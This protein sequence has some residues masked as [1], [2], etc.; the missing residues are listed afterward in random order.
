[1]KQISEIQD[2]CQTRGCYKPFSDLSNSMQL[3][4]NTKFGEELLGLFEQKCD[5]EELTFIT[6]SQK[7]HITYKEINA[8]NINLQIQAIIRLMNS[9]KISRQ[10]YRLILAIRYDLS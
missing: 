9:E 10:A 8:E 4:H 5:F 2:K 1:L 6:N 3:K 7:F